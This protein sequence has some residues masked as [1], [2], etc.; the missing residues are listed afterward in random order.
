M[1]VAD[2]LS[3]R[4][5]GGA[6]QPLPLSHW[7]L[8]EPRDPAGSRA[9][10]GCELGA[11]RALLAAGHVARGDGGD[12]RDEPEVATYGK[13]VA[14]MRSSPAQVDA[15][16]AWPRVAAVAGRVLPAVTHPRLLAGIARIAVVAAEH[17]ATLDRLRDRVRAAAVADSPG[18]RVRDPQLE[19]LRGVFPGIPHYERIRCHVGQQ[20]AETA[21]FL[22]ADE[23]EAAGDAPAVIEPVVVEPPL[24]AFPWPQA[25]EQLGMLVWRLLAAGTPPDK[26]AQLAALARALTPLADQLRHLAVRPAA[27]SGAGA[28]ARLVRDLEIPPRRRRPCGTASIPPAPPAPPSSPPAPRRGARPS[29]SCCPCDPWPRSSAAPGP[30]PPRHADPLLLRRVPP[31]T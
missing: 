18:A 6:P 30:A 12:A 27:L 13:I 23:R 19:G 28:M 4:Y 25:L 17:A 15:L 2:K 5:W 24:A 9:L 10:A 26:R 22:V 3:P 16:A 1:P 7:Y 31:T 21:R 29:A 14:V 8:L 20:I 11:A